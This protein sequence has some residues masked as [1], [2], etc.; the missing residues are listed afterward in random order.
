MIRRNNKSCI[1]TSKNF[2][3]SLEACKIKQ[4]EH[5]V[6]KYSNNE[7][8]GEVIFSTKPIKN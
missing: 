7:V 2:K 4:V 8:A 5:K 1:K 3:D 6:S